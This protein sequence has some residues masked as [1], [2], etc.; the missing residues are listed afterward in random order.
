MHRL[1]AV[2]RL[3]IQRQLAG[4]KR[5]EGVVEAGR[6]WRPAA[7][8]TV[9]FLGGSDELNAEV[10]KVAEEW[11]K[12]CNLKFSFR[13]GA[14]GA[15]RRWSGSDKDFAADIRVSFGE[16]DCW[17]LVGTQARDRRLTRP[18]EPSL[19]LGQFD[20]SLPPG[21]RG[22]VLHEFGHAIG[23]QH[24]HQHPAVPCDFRWDDDDG[25]ELT[26]NE[27]REFVPDMKKRRPGIYTWFSGRPNE[28]SKEKVDRNLKPLPDSSAYLTQ[29]FDDKS[30]MLYALP[31][32]AFKDGPNSHCYHRPNLALSDQDRKVAA[33]AYPHDERLIKERID[34]IEAYE[35]LT[36]GNK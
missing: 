3:V 25:Y 20:R 5:L 31:A 10:A 22:T 16:R 18:D 29:P 19:N 15:L 28:W 24:E 32:W 11:T 17:S 36:Q 1:D 14:T 33:M 27:Q 23:F 35:K 2:S 34:A 21:W 7:T 9:A 13:D 4:R 26:Q 6:T 30:I 12:W 8:V